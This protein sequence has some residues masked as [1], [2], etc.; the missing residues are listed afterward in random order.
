MTPRDHAP[1]D[2]PAWHALNSHHAG[3]A[4]GDALAKRYPPRVTPFAAFA[5]PSEPAYASLAAT[6]DGQSRVAILLDVPSDPPAGWRVV[7]AH[8]ITQMVWEGGALPP[9]A[10]AA[11]E[12]MAPSDVAGMVALAELTKPGPMAERVLELGN[13]YGV[14]Q[15]ARLAAIAGERL[16]PT[17][18]TEVSGV[19][20]HPDFRGRGYAGQL[21]TSL[22]RRITARGET[23]FL[24]L[25]TDNNA[26][27]RVYESLGFRTRRFINLLVTEPPVR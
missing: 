13:Y 3:L 22:V 9:A 24:H 8:P 17:G 16:H 5:E 7:A 23:P 15:G 12:Q 19:C 2:N 14:R 1:L 25:K 20:T 21:V 11:I 26:A 4:V 6:L 18:Y 27:L 10:I